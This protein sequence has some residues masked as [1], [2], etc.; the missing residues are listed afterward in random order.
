MSISL[1]LGVL[2]GLGHAEKAYANAVSV[3][4]LPQASTGAAGRA[5]QYV[6]A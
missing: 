5:I 4:T 3:E 6:T 2:V 1:L